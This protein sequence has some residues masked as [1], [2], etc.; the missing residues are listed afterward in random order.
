MKNEEEFNKRYRE[1]ITKGKKERC[2]FGS[3]CRTKEA[4]KDECPEER[5]EPKWEC[6]VRKEYQLLAMP[7]DV[8]DA[9]LKQIQLRLNRE[10]AESHIIPNGDGLVDLTKGGLRAG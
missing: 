1:I 5:G 4:Y 2:E 10:K 7:E 8:Y 9:R 6:P 3:V